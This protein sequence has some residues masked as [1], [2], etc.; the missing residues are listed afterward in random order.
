M[1][2]VIIIFSLC[3]ASI[4]TISAQDRCDTLKWKVS[5]SIYV[6]PNPSQ[7]AFQNFGKLQGAVINLDTLS[8]FTPGFSLIN[9]SND[10]FFIGE[11][12][13]V[14]SF[15]YAYTDTG[16]Y[17]QYYGIP[18]GYFFGTQVNPNDT[19]PIWLRGGSFNFSDII[20]TFLGQGLNFEQITHWEI[21]NMLLKTS[22]DGQ[23]SDSVIYLGADTAI[24]YLVKTPPTPPSILET[25]QAEISVFPNPAQSH[26]TVT[27]TENAN[28]TLYNILGQ[29]VKQVVGEGENTVIYTEDLPQGIY[30][31]KVEKGD[32][33]LAKKVQ[34]VK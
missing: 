32:A 23:Y 6:K 33:V 22:K 14:M 16:R 10:T 4:F 12:F 30:M 21:R 3:L 24:F 31:L 29:K 19:F 5:K 1:K 18:A 34:I 28:L 25:T 8:A 20:N 15:C 9:I 2:K 11:E 13:H 7:T 27:N 17:D 26:F